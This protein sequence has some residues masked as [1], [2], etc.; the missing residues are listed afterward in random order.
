MQL[1][2]QKLSG[3][4]GLKEGERERRRD[5]FCFSSLINRKKNVT[6]SSSFWR[7][8]QEARC[9]ENWRG[10]VEINIFPASVTERWIRLL[11]KKYCKKVA[12]KQIN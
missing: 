2:F 10:Y 3:K 1:F 4:K 11:S 8:E 9:A 12:E 6:A 7:G 5:G